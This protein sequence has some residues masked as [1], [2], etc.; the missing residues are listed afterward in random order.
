MFDRLLDVAALA[1][2]II[3]GLVHFW[4]LWVIGAGILVGGILI[5]YLTWEHVETLWL[6]MWWIKYLLFFALFV[7]W[8][9]KT[10]GRFNGL[11]LILVIFGWA[12]LAIGKEVEE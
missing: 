5:Y 6:R 3:I 10:P 8:A 7:I 12:I 9:T 2:G 1:A 4:Y 11:M